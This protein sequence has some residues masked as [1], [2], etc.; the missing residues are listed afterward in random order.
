M[1][2]RNIKGRDGRVMRREIKGFIA[3]GLTAILCLPVLGAGAGIG[4]LTEYS[5]EYI[6][7]DE[8]GE[9]LL[10]KVT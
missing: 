6:G 7:R 9:R 1:R 4:K 8:T 3:A 10:E 2:R 5:V